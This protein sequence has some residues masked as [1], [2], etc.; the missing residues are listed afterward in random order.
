MESMIQTYNSQSHPKNITGFSVPS[1]V[2]FWGAVGIT[3]MTGVKR[4]GE[5]MLP[6]KIIKNQWSYFVVCS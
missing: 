3:P 2:A 1:L 6:T 4:A 5:H